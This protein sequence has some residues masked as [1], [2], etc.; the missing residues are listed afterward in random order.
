MA[1]QN[2]PGIEGIA[3][4]IPPVDPVQALPSS[5][6]QPRRRL[7]LADGHALLLQLLAGRFVLVEMQEPHAPQDVGCLGELDVVVAD[8]LDAVAPGIEEVE[9]RLFSAP[10]VILHYILHMKRLTEEP[11]LLVKKGI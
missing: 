9:D 10:L 3:R 5:E 8:D 6:K 4:T 7:S 2:G 11:A 1:L